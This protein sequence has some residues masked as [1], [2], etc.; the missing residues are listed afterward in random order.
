MLSVHRFF[1]ILGAMT[2]AAGA[3]HPVI[4][5]FHL[6]LLPLMAGALKEVGLFYHA[7]DI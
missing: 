5:G 7:V 4:G 2:N 3:Q 6:Y 1:N